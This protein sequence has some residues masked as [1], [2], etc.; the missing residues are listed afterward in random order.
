VQSAE[1][2]CIVAVSFE[3]EALSFEPEL[4]IEP[5]AEPESEIEPEPVS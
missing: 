4:E 2:T 1:P 5:T 3:P